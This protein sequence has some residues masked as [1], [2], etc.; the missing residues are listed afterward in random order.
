MAT[1]LAAIDFS[2]VSERVLDE[3]VSAAKAYGCELVLMHVAAPGPEF[4]GYEV[5]PEVQ[6]AARAE[7]LR[8]EHRWLQ[9]MAD[10]CGGRGVKT[11]A[12]LVSGS[13]ADKL[14]EEAGQL[15]ASMV[16]LGS[17]GHGA[18]YNLLVGSVAGGVL[19]KSACPVLVVP[20]RKG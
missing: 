2:D 6:R 1:L 15:G 17:H 20:A 11:R 7:H 3:A 4:V 12:L 8:A 18:V 5:G 14:V 10:R 16:V 19:K 13:T 9:E